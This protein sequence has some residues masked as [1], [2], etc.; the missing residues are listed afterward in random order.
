MTQWYINAF[1]LTGMLVTA[2]VVYILL[3][4]SDEVVNAMVEAHRDRSKAA[5][6]LQYARQT[7]SQVAEA[8]NY[9][10]CELSE[11]LRRFGDMLDPKVS[12]IND[13]SFVLDAAK[14]KED[15]DLLLKRI[16]KCEE[17]IDQLTELG[18]HLCGADWNSSDPVAIA[19]RESALGDMAKLIAQWPEDFKVREVP[20]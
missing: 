2:V 3:I 4:R 8:A 6:E 10:K 20:G 5:R 18:A 19:H 9:F 11:T 7:Q 17:M 13:K 14:V 16:A 12:K 1:F 15:R